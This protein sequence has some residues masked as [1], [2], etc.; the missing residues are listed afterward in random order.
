MLR[1]WSSPCYSP[2]VHRLI[3]QRRRQPALLMAACAGKQPGIPGSLCPVSKPPARNSIRPCGTAMLSAPVR[4]CLASAAS[5]GAGNAAG[6]EFPQARRAGGLQA[7]P[8]TPGWHA[9]TAPPSA[10]TLTTHPNP[11]LCG[12]RGRYPIPPS[13]RPASGALPPPAD[14][15]GAASAIQGLACAP[16]RRGLSAAS[17]LI[18]IALA[19]SAGAAVGM[20]IM[21]ALFVPMAAGSAGV[22]T[23]CWKKCRL[24]TKFFRVC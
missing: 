5:I 12:G 21:T 19:G 10:Q 7:G 9:H 17:G 23:M 6:R 4:S 11:R 1:L 14:P 16:W 13:E 15:T 24:S 3:H 20:V 8:H 2:P 22:K 18:A